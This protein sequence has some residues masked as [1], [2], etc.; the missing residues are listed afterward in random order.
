MPNGATQGKIDA[1]RGN[2]GQHRCKNGVTQGSTDAKTGQHSATP[3]PKR[4][5]TGQH[6][7]QNGASGGAGGL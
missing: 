3:M 1:K 4:G 6:R 2:T 5:N 7:C